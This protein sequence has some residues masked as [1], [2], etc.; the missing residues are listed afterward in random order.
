[1]NEPAAPIG[2]VP[3]VTAAAHTAEVAGKL[4]P[5]PFTSAQRLN[6]QKWCLLNH[7]LEATPHHR[8]SKGDANGKLRAA[9]QRELELTPARATELREALAS[10]HYITIAKKGRSVTYELT[11]TGREY[12]Q[13]LDPYPPEPPVEPVPETVLRHQMAHVLFQLFRAEGQTLGRG[14]ANQKR[15][16]TDLE[17]T[18]QAANKLRKQLAKQGA[19]EIIK[20]SRSESYRLTPRGEELLATLEHYPTSKVTLSGRLLNAL[21]H[22]V[23]TAAPQ[24]TAVSTEPV[25][26]SAPQFAPAPADLSQAI[27]E[28]FEEL[29]R[30][31]HSHTGLVPIHEIRK[32][33][34]ANYGP[35]LARHDVLDEPIREL[36]RQG[37]LRMVALADLQRATPE[38]LND[39]VPGVHETLFYLER[40][41]ERPAQ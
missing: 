13:M 6:F 31:R 17:L 34:A 21:L 14:Q 41:H 2:E 20:G 29:L 18:P 33:I 25:V 28:V 32:Q 8:L 19:L 3:V 30:E 23:R 26:T 1:V 5:P 38:Q 36:W 7:L 24:P 27:H 37:R 15:G 22:T 9:L 12:L 11:D 39:S 16:P 10:E 40:A 35:N 4:E